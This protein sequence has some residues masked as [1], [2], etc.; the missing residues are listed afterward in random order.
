LRVHRVAEQIKCEKNDVGTA[1]NG[2]KFTASFVKTFKPIQ[3]PPPPPHTH[4]QCGDLKQ[5]LFL[6]RKKSRLKGAESYSKRKTAIF[7]AIRIKN[8]SDIKTAYLFIHV[9]CGVFVPCDMQV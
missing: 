9:A 5:L 4:T 7:A 1:S 6:F 3:N 2:I 8:T